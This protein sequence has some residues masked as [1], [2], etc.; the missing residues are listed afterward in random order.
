[1]T[2]LIN[3]PINTPAFIATPTLVKAI[4]VDTM[5]SEEQKNFVG[6]FLS[7]SVDCRLPCWWNITPGQAREEAKKTIQS[8]GGGLVPGESWYDPEITTYGTSIVL[9]NVLP[10]ESTISLEEKQGSVYAWHILGLGGVQ[11][12]EKF[13][14][15][16]KNYLAQEVVKT[17]GMPD[18]IFLRGDPASNPLQY[19]FYSLWLFY[20]ELGFSIVYEARIP[21]YFFDAPFFRIC[22]ETDPLLNIKIHTQSPE[23]PLSLERFDRT[24]EDVLLGTDIGKLMVIT[25]LQEATGL[26]NEELYQAFMQE[27]DAC[28]AV[29]SDIWRPNR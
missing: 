23:N 8:Y 17:Y 11:N 27:K 20:D 12:P 9:K 13:R 19:G 10:N 25:S 4:P 29:P 7:D 5:T 3:T 18:R 15:T 16:W 21:M 22:S 14:R 1:L 26:S 28:L 6:D 24:F 2:T